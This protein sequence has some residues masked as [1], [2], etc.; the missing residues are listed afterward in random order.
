MH[1]YFHIPLTPPWP[2]PC[3][4]FLLFISLLSLTFISPWLTLT[5]LPLIPVT[6]LF[7]S[8]SFS[9]SSLVVFSLPFIS[10]YFPSHI[11]RF[12]PSLLVILRFSYLP[13]LSP[14]LQIYSLF[15][16]PAPPRFL[17]PPSFLRPMSLISGEWEWFRKRSKAVVLHQPFFRALFYVCSAVRLPFH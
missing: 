6:F 13:Y 7:F 11:S 14:L 10:L 8:L 4:F 2:F 15:I 16:P 9:F 12:C 3:C 5:Y 1:L 17:S